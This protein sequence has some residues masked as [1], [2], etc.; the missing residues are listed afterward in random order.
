MGKKLESLASQAQ[1]NADAQKVAEEI[2]AQGQLMGL[3]FN[4]EVFEKEG[5]P[6]KEM[7]SKGFQGAKGLV[8]G[9]GAKAVAGAKQLGGKAVEAGKSG[10]S[11]VH[12]AAGAVGAKVP[13]L[14]KASPKIQHT[15]GYGLMAAGTGAVGAG[16][17]AGVRAIKDRNKTASEPQTVPAADLILRY[18]NDK[19]GE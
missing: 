6:F 2:I 5:A 7:L 12:G 3:G 18:S 1:P 10:L 13:G 4:Y 11:K 17:V 15:A 8:T 19:G 9:A 16:G 14:G